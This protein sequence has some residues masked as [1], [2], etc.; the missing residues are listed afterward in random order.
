MK[1][2]KIC[3][4]TGLA[5]LVFALLGGLYVL[6]AVTSM[7]TQVLNAQ[8]IDRRNILNLLMEVIV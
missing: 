2:V 6:W 4:L 3:C 8:K 7:H 5:I 1:Y